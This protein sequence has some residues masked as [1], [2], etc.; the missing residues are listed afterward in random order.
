MMRGVFV[1]EEDLDCRTALGEVLEELGLRPVLFPDPRAAVAA[2]ART[3]PALIVTEIG[4]PGTPFATPFHALL[5]AAARLEVPAIVFSGWK[6]TA[7]GPHLPFPFIAKPEIPL[8]L[9][10]IGALVPQPAR[11]A[12]TAGR[13][14][15]EPVVDAA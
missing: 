7:V 5:A 8:L 4:K 3:P 9:K 10:M 6:P 1:V 12:G 13:P 14:R 2:L 11:R 15:V